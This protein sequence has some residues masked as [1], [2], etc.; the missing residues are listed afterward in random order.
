MMKAGRT[1]V[2]LTIL[3]AFALAWQIG[4]ASA[5]GLPGGPTFWLN[6]E[7]GAEYAIRPLA[8]SDEGDMVTGQLLNRRR[9]GL[10]IR[11]IPMGFGYRY[12]G[13]GVWF[14]GWRESVYLYFSKYR[15]IACTVAWGPDR[16]R[17]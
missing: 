1:A 10:H 7:N 16:V 3:T 13:R 14:D 11:L 9:Q 15:P 17:G 12:A 6:C 5:R 4:H 2:L 8:V